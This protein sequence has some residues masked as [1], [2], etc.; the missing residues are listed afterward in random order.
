MSSKAITPAAEAAH[1]LLRLERLSRAGQGS[2][3][4][5]PAQ[6]EALR[7]VARANRFSRNPAAVAVYFGA[8]RGTVSQTLIA[9]EEKGMLR[10]LPSK[11]DRRGIDLALTA[12]GEQMLREDPLHE[13][14]RDLA[15][16]KSGIETTL[17]HLRGAVRAAVRRNGGRAFGFCHA[18]AHFRRTPLSPSAAPNH[19]ALLQEPL[20]D[21]DSALI[22]VE[23]EEAA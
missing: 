23:Q 11:A 16:E 18:C 10:R 8:T 3:G 1:L 2:D 15:L 20:T 9:L 12:R 21:A 7:Y 14:A 22:C 6:W 17:N 5:N 19:C 13:L 4:L